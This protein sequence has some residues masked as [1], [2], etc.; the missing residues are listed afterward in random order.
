MVS[1][2]VFGL[3]IESG[4]LRI[5]PFLTAQMRRAL[6]R[7]ARASL[8]HLNYLGFPL[9]IT[10][11]LP[12]V[13][14]AQG[15]YAV[16]R[17]RLNG[18]AVSGVLARR[19]LRAQD[20]RIEVD[21]GA[22]RSGDAR[23]SRAAE[24]KSDSHQDVRV[25]APQAPRL[26]HL[27]R[28]GDQVALRFSDDL[29]AAAGLARHYHLYRDGVRVQ[30]DWRSLEWIDADPGSPQVR[31]CYAIEAVFDGSRNHSHHSEPACLEEGAVQT[32]WVSDARVIS[33]VAVSPASD[34]LAGP[35]LRHWGLPEHA[36]AFTQVNVSH[37]GRY[38]LELLYNNHRFD[39]SSGVTNAVKRLRVLDA[40]GTPVAQG[41][42]Q[43]PNVEPRGAEHPMRSSTQLR[44]QLP[45]GN[46]RVELQDEFN[47]SYLQANASYSGSGGSGGPV[48]DAN[49]AA[50]RVIAL[51]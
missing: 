27:L 18:R 22:L 49:I 25:F 8:Q 20:N 44:V 42:V 17:V 14:T 34:G 29:N 10:L 50:L 37:A 9:Q 5:E 36:L 16:R 38:G 46:Y 47:M 48:N 19:Q 31:H 4:G 2:T 12:A 51:P 45:A 40:T 23:L 21:F 7:G 3:H 15:Y 28:S 43:M 30:S 35:T 33:N 13:T 24:V 11:H 6:G 26:D 39:I 1:D 32:V 41:V